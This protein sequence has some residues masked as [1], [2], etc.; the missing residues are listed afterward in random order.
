MCSLVVTLRMDFVAGP[1]ATGVEPTSHL[2]T[3][4]S[5]TQSPSGG[6]LYNK[7]LIN[8]SHRTTRIPMQVNIKESW[9]HVL[10]NI[11]QDT[12]IITN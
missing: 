10:C 9:H 4:Q 1:T 2:T 5:Q 8:T 11:F 7:K 12:C 6:S 3:L